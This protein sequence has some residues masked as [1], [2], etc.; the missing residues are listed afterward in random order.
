MF[1]NLEAS[2]CDDPEDPRYEL[3]CVGNSTEASSPPKHQAARIV[4]VQGRPCPKLMCNCRVRGA[5]QVVHNPDQTVGTITLTNK[6]ANPRQT[7]VHNPDQTVANPR[8]TV[9]TITLT[10]FCRRI[11][12]IEKLFGC[13]C[14]S[15]NPISTR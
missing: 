6:I 13:K 12:T 15:T 8:Q 7:L 9:G 2:I 11:R 14:N 3:F 5:R 1:F 4:A 10:Q